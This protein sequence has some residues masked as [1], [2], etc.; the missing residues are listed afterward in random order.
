MTSK[1]AHEE[2]KDRIRELEVE[3]ARLLA[4]SEAFAAEDKL[5]SQ[6]VEGTPIATFVIDRKHRI[7]H[8]NR[9]WEKLTG[10]SA[11]ELIG[12]RNQWKTFYPTSR[13][14][15]ADLIVD[16]A[17]E[18]EFKKFY[19]DHYRKS[20]VIKG[21]YEAEKFF[22]SLGESGKWLFFT[23]S[24]IRDENGEITGAVETLQDVTERKIAEEKL[25]DSERRMRGLLEFLPH[26]IVVFSVNGRV[27]YLNPAFTETFGWT[28]DELRGKNIP[29]VPPGLESET[30]E[31]IDRLFLENAVVGYETKRLT[32]D[33]RLLDVVMSAS[34]YQDSRGNL[35]GE[36]VMLRD[37]T[38]EKRNAR[39]NEA[40]RRISL[41][42]PA[43]PD[44]EDL[45]DFISS[46][47]KRLI[48]S[49]GA[50]VILLD[51]ENQVL[52]F[53]GA[54]F[55]DEVTSD[56]VKGFRFPVDRLVAGQVIKSGEPR[57]VSDVTENEEIHRERDRKF[58]YT[59]RNLLLVPLKSSDR[60][61][62]V[63]AS[64]NK[65]E[66]VFDKADQ[67]FLGMIA[68]T[69]A[70]SVEN[71][72]FSEDLKEAYR[73]NETLLRI[74]KALPMYPD[75]EDLLDFISG[76]VQ[77]I[78]DS[79]GALIGLLEDNERLFFPGVSYLDKHVQ[80][81]MK[82]LRVGLDEVAAGKV[83]RT[84]APIIANDPALDQALYPDRDNKLGYTTRNFIE[85]PL[86]SSDRIIG[87]LC[88]IN[89]REGKFDEK[90]I[91]LLSLI[92]GTV[93]ISIENARFSEE[94]KKAYLEVRSLN[95]A[96]DKAI[97]HLSHELKTPVSVL[98]GSLD[99]LSKRLEDL[100]SE[101]W[102]P[103]MERVRRN[104]RRIVEIQEEVDDI[105]QERSSQKREMLFTL[106]DQ[107]RD[108]IET[109][110]ATEMGENQAI[111][112]V[113][114]R[115]D[116]IYG[117]R[118]LVSETIAMD[119]FV[120]QRLE[121]R[122]ELFAHRD[123]DLYVDLA[124][125]LD[126]FLPR[127]ILRKVIDGLIKNA[128]ENTPDE[129]RIEVLLRRKMDAAVFMVRDYGVGITED[130]RRR[131]FE[132]FFATQDTLHYSSKRPYDFNAGGKGA[133]LLR[134]RIFSE[135][136]GF[137]IEMSSERCRCIPL[138][139]D[140][141]PGR[142]SECEDCAAG[143]ETCLQSGGTT[144]T[145]TFPLHRKEEPAGEESEE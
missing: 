49:E 98:V 126:V 85:V 15:M 42:L 68:T 124:P 30:K 22:P 67:E 120:K 54:A 112:R 141:C 5:F 3:N 52:Y 116:E 79:E 94:L 140:V 23:A 46:E 59:T 105:I 16:K 122:A 107:C 32:R 106:I 61:I 66:G 9:A 63:I 28:L 31:A 133:D 143:R 88:A 34:F 121:E 125:G 75:L 19:K 45:L 56:R 58:G 84:G 142:I 93:A 60:T 113:R 74:S 40:L 90:D 117:P 39:N 104:L 73:I 145:V 44:M 76:E 25:R 41:A 20:A 132:G 99:I 139:T 131:I 64:I 82:R 27:Y 135:K 37:I 53:M 1:Q 51:E 69:V 119:D 62:G 97:N 13:P 136:Y 48:N 81:R 35:L 127:D 80:N 43:Y 29:Y 12:T 65:K 7:T 47:V 129:G 134:M 118:D 95:R 14:V 26:P 71:A 87:V 110:L 6:I 101:K 78:M 96:K 18:E 115:I 91:N 50:L 55:D 70:L 2:L 89:K 10:I 144:F 108:Q 111:E 92:G 128:I 123:V 11:S 4:A 137:K 83:I 17:S 57:I 130:A 138:E 114:A 21:A 102:Q 8:C 36:L 38:Q 24:P 86:K 100:A 72:R 109:I 77:R 33:G 103:T